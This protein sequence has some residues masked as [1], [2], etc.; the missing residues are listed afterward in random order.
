M[1]PVCCVTNVPGLHQRICLTPTWIAVPPTVL[2]VFSARMHVLRGGAV[3]MTS[4]GA[5]KMS[6]HPVAC[7]QRAPESA[8]NGHDMK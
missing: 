8:E 6:P 7:A 2:P 5:D 1:S 3:G 4:H